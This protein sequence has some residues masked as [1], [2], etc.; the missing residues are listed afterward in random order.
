MRAPCCADD[1]IGKVQ[2]EDREEYRMKGLLRDHFYAAY[3]NGKSLVRILFVA[4]IAIVAVYPKEALIRYYMLL[5]LVM[6]SFVAL[7]A[8]GKDGS[9]RWERYKLTMPVT[10]ADIVRSCYVGQ[11]LW[12]FA[13]ILLSGVAVVLSVLLHGF[14]FDRSTDVWLIYVM[15]VSISLFMGAI[16]YPLS[17]LCGE[18]AKGASLVGSTFLAV[19]IVIG[20]AMLW[21]FLFGPVMAPA[22]ISLGGAVILLCALAAY[23][24]S[25]F[26]TVG[27]FRRKDNF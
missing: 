4:G 12:M 19:A 25:F 3:A 13:G 24:G 2:A 5:C 10:R 11:F 1:P 18:E 17:C 8:F 16:F 7:P 22:M 27:I 14:L 21:N 26:L 6:I 15:G 9:C 23:V 20:L